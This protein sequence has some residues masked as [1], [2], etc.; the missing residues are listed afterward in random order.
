MWTFYNSIPSNDVRISEARRPADGADH[1]W[2]SERAEEVDH[3][4]LDLRV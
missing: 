1:S 3:R 2:Y 4:L